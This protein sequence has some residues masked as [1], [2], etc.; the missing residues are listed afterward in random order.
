MNYMCIGN[1]LAE[2][3]V[4]KEYLS[5]MR[6]DTTIEVL[7]QNGWERLRELAKVGIVSRMNMFGNKSL[8][9]RS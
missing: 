3:R 1:Q 6:K 8:T 5:H 9:C 4:N 7:S 2:P